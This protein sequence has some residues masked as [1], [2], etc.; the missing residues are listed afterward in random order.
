[1]KRRDEEG[2]YVWVFKKPGHQDTVQLPE[3]PK[4]D[5]TEEVWWTI[6]VVLLQI[7]QAI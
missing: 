1:M 4:P 6:M 7:F 5:K 3:P 2:E